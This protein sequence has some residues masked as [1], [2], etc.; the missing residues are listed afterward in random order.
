MPRKNQR[1][2]QARTV[3]TFAAASFLNDLGADAIRPFWPAFV[4][5]ALGAPAAVLGLLDGLGDLISYGSKFPAGW[6][7]D[8]I[9]RRKPLVWLGYLLA[10]FSRIGYAL[11]PAVSWLFPLKATE[12]LGKLRDPP[13]DALLADITP[14]KQR[15]RAFGLLA[16]MDNFG[17]ALGPIFGILLFALLSYRGTFA[18]AAI[19]S[20]IGALA[21][22]LIV[23]ER[24]P[25]PFRL[26]KKKPLGAAFRHLTLLSALFAL[27]WISLSFMVLHAITREGMPVLLA[28]LL[29]FVMSIAATFA[30]SAMG[31]ASDRIGRKPALIISYAIYPLVA[32]GFIVAHMLGLS[33]A[34]GT[35]AALGLFALYGLHYGSMSAVQPAYVTGLVPSASRAY[36]S[37]LFQSAFGIATFIASIAAGL[38]WDIISPAATFGYALVVSTI[39]IAA[40]ATF[41]K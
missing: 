24:R 19:P 3:R 39:A 34:I 9:R 11:A 28:P 1:A 41:L 4:T 27:S 30:S 8:K 22:A 6:L 16:A 20:I 5:G 13:R 35:I 38:L 7:S 18:I 36:A 31:R 25:K 29:F 32:L 15:G 21:I 10:G 12:R 2:E 23:H 37:G 17:A 40:I 33:G 14:K 26:G